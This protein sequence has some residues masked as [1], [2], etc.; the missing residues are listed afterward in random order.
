MVSLRSGS[1]LA[2]R[3]TLE[4]FLD[5]CTWSDLVFPLEFCRFLEICMCWFERPSNATR[6]KMFWTISFKRPTNGTQTKK[7]W[8]VSFER[9]CERYTNAEALEHLVRT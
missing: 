7:L 4:N 3:I 9:L 5:L 1:V 6:T 8:K 2:P